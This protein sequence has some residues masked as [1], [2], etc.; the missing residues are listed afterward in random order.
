[1]KIDRLDYFEA[2][3]K[4][5]A[6]ARELI[7]EAEILA[8]KNK[9]AR[10][11]SLFQFSIEEVGKAFLTFNFLLKGD[12][13][14]DL[15]TKKFQ[16]DYKNHLAKTEFSQGIDFM[17][18]IMAEKSDLTTKLLENS[19]FELGKVHISNNY[20]NFSL[21]TSLIDNKFNKPSEII[22]KEKLDN[23]A[24]YAKFRLQIAEPF[25]KL[26]IQNFDI[27]YETRNN[28][29]EEATSIKSYKKIKE[30]LKN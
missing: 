28:L 1:M 16:N 6:N 17:F 12:I 18:A 5:L 22:T 21:Y 13:E 10:A 26:G 9:V 29:D 24:Y 3:E 8:E 20:K 2:I 23:I 4:S 14:S 11:Y 15:E 30:I 27:L 25:L 19:F 7:E